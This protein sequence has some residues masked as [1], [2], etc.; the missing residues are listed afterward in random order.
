V[1][2]RQDE[3]GIPLVTDDLLL[4]MDTPRRQ[5]TIGGSA[6]VAGF[7]YWSGRDVRVEFRPAAV[8]EGIVFV[9]RDLPGTPRIPAHIAYRVEQPRRSSLRCAGAGV[10]MVEHVMAA[11]GGLR[12][13]NCQVWVDEAEMPGCDGSAMP[14][15]E[16]IDSACIVEQDAI[17]PQ[18]IVEEAIRLGDRDSWIEARP[19]CG[20]QPLF[21]Y[22]LD[23]GP[24]SPIVP[25]TCAMQLSPDAF[26][27]ELAPC[28]TFMLKAE[29]DWLVARG[30]GRR[31]RIQDLLIYGA[32][33]P[34]DNHERFPDECARH[35]LL[36]MVGD[37]TLAGCDL[38]GAFTAHR[39]GHRLNAELVRV[40]ASRS[41]GMDRQKR[42]A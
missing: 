24:E 18:W 36:D 42:C 6:T 40:L 9:R 29:A 38:V 19:V 5:R 26:R 41:E 30:I 13:D 11:L 8:N 31:T 22:Q 2:W 25:R 12:I 32:D 23:Y 21:E 39:S 17:R 1:G 10:D 15:V 33:G 20:G 16:A 35:K 4:S 34:I 14:F 27:R 37:L 3:N 7:G 28:R